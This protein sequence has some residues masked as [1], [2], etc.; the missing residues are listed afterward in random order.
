MLLNMLD[1]K[2]EQFVNLEIPEYTDELF[3]NGREYFFLENALWK[4]DGLA[5]SRPGQAIP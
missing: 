2:V 1:N 5:D 4:K 3:P